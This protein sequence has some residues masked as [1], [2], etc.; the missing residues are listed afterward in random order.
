MTLTIEL[1]KA[2]E[3]QLSERAGLEG[4]TVEVLACELIQKAVAP[5]KTF[6]EILGP[7]RQSVAESGMTEEELD[8]LVEEA[9]NEIW[10]EKQGAKS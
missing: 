7:F 10:Q 6:D 2:V 9:R 4:K 1:P 3:R 5:E 8:A